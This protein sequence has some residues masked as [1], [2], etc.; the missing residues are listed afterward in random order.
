MTI[1]TLFFVVFIIACPVGMLL[2]MR[3]GHSIGRGAHTMGGGAD[4]N[5]ADHEQHIA[6]LE[7]ENARLR[8]TA[9]KAGVPGLIGRRG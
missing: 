5:A 1:G 3:G 8:G 4:P 9:P 7:R 6:D 2:M